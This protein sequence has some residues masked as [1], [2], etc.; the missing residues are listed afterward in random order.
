MDH[1]TWNVTASP[2]TPSTLLAD[3][4]ETLA[5]GTGTRHTRPRPTA[6][7]SPSIQVASAPPT[8]G[9]GR[10]RGR[11]VPSASSAVIGS[12]KR[13]ALSHRGL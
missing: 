9:T 2:Y 7:T 3:L 5:H 12:V 8:R 10:T 1:P 11:A 6:R 13:A 4:T